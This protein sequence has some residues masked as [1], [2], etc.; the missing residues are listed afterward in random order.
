LVNSRG[1]VFWEVEERANKIPNGRSSLHCLLHGETLTM[2]KSDG[3]IPPR[4]PTDTCKL[5]ITNDGLCPE[6]RE[7]YEG[8]WLSRDNV[9]EAINAE[10]KVWVQGVSL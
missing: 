1:A 5:Q 3:E 2:E 10:N 4:C 8:R 9:G 7:D 6:T